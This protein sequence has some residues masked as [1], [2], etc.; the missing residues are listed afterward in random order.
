MKAL[1]G[2]LRRTYEPV[3]DCALNAL[4]GVQT[5][6]SSGA[7]GPRETEVWVQVFSAYGA[8]LVSYME[9]DTK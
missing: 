8:L 6:G 5:Q 3:T 7:A 1:T 4:P 9:L 2:Q